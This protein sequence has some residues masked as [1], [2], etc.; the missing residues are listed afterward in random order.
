MLLYS[1]DFRYMLYNLRIYTQGKYLKQFF[2][3]IYIQVVNSYIRLIEKSTKL[4]PNRR[5]IIGIDCVP[6]VRIL[7]ATNFDPASREFRWIRERIQLSSGT[8][9][10]LP[11]CRQGHWSL[12]VST[13]NNFF[14]V[15]LFK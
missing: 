2:V 4:L 10:L 11:V 5:A 14:N 6:F 1:R 13:I 12:L 9:Y 7:R 3:I 15:E 8:K